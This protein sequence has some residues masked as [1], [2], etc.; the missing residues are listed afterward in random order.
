MTAALQLPSPLE[1]P[2][3]LDPR[4]LDPRL[5]DPRL[6]DVKDDWTVDDLANFPEDLRYELID[7]RLILPSPTQFHQD[8]CNQIANMIQP[9]CPSGYRAVIDVS[10][11][12]DQDSEPR[13]DVV[14][15]RISRGKRSP[16][17]IAGALLLVEVISPTSRF[18]D[19]Y[20]KAK[21]FASAGVENY[22]VVDPTFKQGV[23]LTEYRIGESGQYD[24]AAS[25][26]GVFKTESP[27]PI[28]VDVPALT[29]LRELYD[30]EE[31]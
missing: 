4:L 16:A 19:M 7:G 11:S 3:A 10:L 26:N 27:F 25:T 18:R 5:L 15:A 29:A 23:V 2:G 24:M 12:V 14:V 20:L 9:S 21:L 13:P 8:V 6:L 30:A 1:D 31:D 22:W 17:P 28:T